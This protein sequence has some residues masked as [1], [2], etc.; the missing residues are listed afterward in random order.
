MS[1]E[2]CLTREELLTALK[3]LDIAHENGFKHS[4]AIVQLVQAGECVDKFIAK[5]DSLILK[6]HPT[7]PS[8]DWGRCNNPEWYK[9]V[10]GKCVEV[11]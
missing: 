4:L 10:R 8:K 1:I 3:Q 7:N 6:A 2:M 11:E 9:M 5:Y